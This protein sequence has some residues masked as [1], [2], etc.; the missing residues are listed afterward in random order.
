MARQHTHKCIESVLNFNW[1]WVI[2]IVIFV[3]LE[4]AEISI[5]LI[6]WLE[7][8]PVASI[9]I[10]LF[11]LVPFTKSNWFVLNITIIAI[12]FP[13]FPTIRKLKTSSHVFNGSGER[14]M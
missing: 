8:D 10:I 7:T 12:L 3:A 11:V 6:Y 13:I 1:F 2:E 4:T 5:I 9:L 14:I